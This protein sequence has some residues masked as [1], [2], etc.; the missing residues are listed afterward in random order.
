M[1]IQYRS[2]EG[3]KYYV[4]KKQGYDTVRW[5]NGLKNSDVLVLRK[6]KPY[7]IIKGVTG[8]SEVVVWETSGRLKMVDGVEGQTWSVVGSD[9]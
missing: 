3:F 8:S 9:V 6:K 1:N 7:V 5:Y 2:L 4:W